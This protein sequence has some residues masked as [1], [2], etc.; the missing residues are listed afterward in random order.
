M[1]SS[2]TVNLQQVQVA[3]DALWQTGPPHELFR[4][5]RRECPVHWSAGIEQSPDDAGFWSVT[6]AEDVHTVSRDWETY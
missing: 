5:M 6:K 1:S 3:D 2:E 4:Q